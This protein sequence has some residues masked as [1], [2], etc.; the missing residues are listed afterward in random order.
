MGRPYGGGHLFNPPT[1]RH[2]RGCLRMPT[3]L[4]PKFL[5]NFH[6]FHKATPPSLFHAYPFKKKFQKIFHIFSRKV[7]IF[8]VS[9]LIFHFFYYRFIKTKISTTF[10]FRNA[11]IRILYKLLYSFIIYLFAFI[12]YYFCIRR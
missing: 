6:P 12:F 5:E 11:Y 1:H 3:V 8:Y 7:I 10:I 2:K 4:R 9:I